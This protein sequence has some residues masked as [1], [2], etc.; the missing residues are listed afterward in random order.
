M[1]SRWAA[2]NRGAVAFDGMSRSKK[3]IDFLRLRHPPAR[4]ERRQRQLGKHGKVAAVRG[5][6]PQQVDEPLEDPRAA[7][8]PLDRSHLAGPYRDEP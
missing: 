2:S 6:L 5:G 4:K 1:P 8:A 7:I 3:R